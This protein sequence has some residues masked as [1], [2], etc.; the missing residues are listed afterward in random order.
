MYK[1]RVIKEIYM[2]EYLIKII[3]SGI[4]AWLYTYLAELYNI[5]KNNGSLLQYI[6]D[7][8]EV[9]YLPNPTFVISVMLVSAVFFYWD[10]IH[11]TSKRSKFV[12]KDKYKNQH[13]KPPKKY[14]SNQ[15]K[16]FTLGKYKNKFFN[17]CIQIGNIFHV[18]IIGSP[19]TGKSSTL[20]S[21]F[22][23]ILKN[24]QAT[25]FALDIK[26]EICRKS[27]EIN[28]KNIMYV[29]PTSRDG[30][31]FDP[32]YLLEGDKSTDDELV[33]VLH[34]ISL[35]LI[36]RLSNADAIWSESARNVFIGF[37][38]FG[39]RSGKGFI[40]CMLQILYVPMTDLITEICLNKDFSRNHPKI[41]SYLNGYMDDNETTQSI[42]V[43][44][45]QS[46][47]IFA[48]ENVKWKLQDCPIKANPSMLLND[49]SIFVAL[50]DNLLKEYSPI[51]RLITQSV[52]DFLASTSDAERSKDNAKRIFLII[53]EFGSIGNLEIIEPLA[54][55]RSRNISIW[56]AI[57]GISQLDNTYG[58]NIRRTIMDNCSGKIIFSN[59]DKETADE[60]SS[61][62]GKYKETKTSSTSHGWHL[63]GESSTTVGDEYH[64]I[65][66]NS[67]L[68]MLKAN[69]E[70][71]CIL[72][73]GFYLL[74]KYPYYKIPE[75]NTYSKE[76]VRRND[77]YLNERKK[78]NEH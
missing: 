51:L 63:I 35:S 28:S 66:E 34:S 75:L 49:I 11:I 1:P 67:D 70:L 78:E 33:D 17:L 20:I 25:F 18:L 73:D 69:D 46:L 39:Y 23:N 37:M 32:F 38:A 61:I 5:I 29:D 6:L 41:V 48:N 24:N 58:K 19:G 10:P 4:V 45:R 16:E 12:S 3:G 30:P 64:A 54:R 13:R 8:N 55:F 14:L 52:L 76:M 9:N 21:G 68:A 44:L 74:Q 50:K 56:L 26:P 53:D 27:A 15:S 71:L 42:K 7:G 77:S 31:G 57:Q 72:D 2:K 60:I 65:I 59:T 47:Q 36:P 43:T 40:D 22:I 62:C